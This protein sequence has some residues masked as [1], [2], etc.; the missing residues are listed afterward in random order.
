MP[1]V[2]CGKADFSTVSSVDAKS[3]QPLHVACCHG[4][5]L[6]QQDPC[7]S[8]QDLHH[9]YTHQYRTDYKKTYA[10]KP[11]HIYRAG[12]LAVERL[13]FLQQH[14]IQGG[15]LLDIGAGGGEFVSLAQSRGYDS[16]GVEPNIGYSEFAKTQYGVDVMTGDFQRISGTY[17]VITM[18]HVLEHVPDPVNT[19]KR[20]WALLAEGGYLCVE[21]P[22]I[23]TR[24]AS[25]HNI[26]FKAH[27]FYFSRAALAAC[28]SPYFEPVVTDK[29]ANLRMLFRRR[30]QETLMTVPSPEEVAHTIRRLRQKGWIEYLFRGG[31]LIKGIM[32]LKDRF[33]ES[34][35]QKKAGRDILAGIQIQTATSDEH[36]VRRHDQT[37]GLHFGNTLAQENTPAQ[38]NSRSKSC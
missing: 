9:F 21:V 17:Q 7:P 36:E 22:N 8:E 25:P 2:L 1:C 38:E 30:Q 35:Y 28:A 18:F 37:S 32:K 13:N 20:L 26:F 11:K 4:C 6:V 29:R 10:P 5:G 23:E 12:M 15:T 3:H 14:G 16:H 19:F 27:L 31:G 33:K 34:S 24:D